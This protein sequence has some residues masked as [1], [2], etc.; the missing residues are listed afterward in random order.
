M[1]KP[2]LSSNYTKHGMILIASSPCTWEDNFGKL[3]SK[4]TFDTSNVQKYSKILGI[5]T[6]P[7]IFK[8]ILGNQST[9]QKSILYPDLKK[10][11][12]EMKN[13]IDW[14]NIDNVITSV[15]E[16]FLSLDSKYGGGR[17][18][19]VVIKYDNGS[20]ILKFQQ[21]YQVDQAARAI[22]KAK[23]KE[24]SQ[25]LEQKYWDQIRLNA[26]NIITVVT[27]GKQVKY[28]DLPRELKKCADALKKLKLT[29]THSKKNDLQ[30]KDDIMG[31]ITMILKKNLKGNNGS[32]VLGRFQ[33]L[34]LG[35]EK[36]LNKAYRNSDKLVICIVRA[37]KP[38]LEKNP[39]PLELQE[40][41]IKEIYPKVDIIVHSTGNIFSIMQ[42][43]TFNINTVY[44]GTDR[45]AEY[46]KA[47]QYNPDINVVETKR[48]DSDIS[49]TK[50]RESIRTDN[51]KEFKKL[52]DKKLWKYFDIM[53]KYLK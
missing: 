32:L 7:V 35:H 33:P 5:P 8:G 37:R 19:G 1:K 43:S 51:I 14:S 13:S 41:M 42:K 29:F 27:R 17:E 39:F 22:I 34:T 49:A 3:K 21:I 26:L 16:M 48:S 36:I 50:V 4:S 44:V 6:P 40:K 38:D 2:T 30:I 24:P 20:R 47:L 28:I 52:M 15:S 23:F 10:V 45:A 18:E 11:Y 9:F 12:N 53:K 46:R 25:E 31:N